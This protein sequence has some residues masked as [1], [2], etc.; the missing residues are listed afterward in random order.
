MVLW[1]FAR[2]RLW[3]AKN[4]NQEVPPPRCTTGHGHGWDSGLMFLIFSVSLLI[5]F[6]VLL[7]CNY[8][9]W[10]YCGSTPPRMPSVKIIKPLTLGR[11]SLG[12]GDGEMGRKARNRRRMALIVS[13]TVPTNSSIHGCVFYFRF[14][15]SLLVLLFS[16]TPLVLKREY[17]PETHADY[18]SRAVRRRDSR[19]I[20]NRNVPSTN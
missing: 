11:G 3:A 4:I 14:R 8:W 15:S 9:S 10:S 7:Y 19:L 2:L 1:S 5:L 17:M 20:P 16:L 6:L 13:N 12:I 18:Y